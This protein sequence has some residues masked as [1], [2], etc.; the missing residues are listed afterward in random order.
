MQSVN[1]EHTTGEIYYGD[2]VHVIN[3]L[4]PFIELAE[5]VSKM[6]K[7]G[8]INDIRRVIANNYVAQLRKDLKK[9]SFHFAIPVEDLENALRS[10]D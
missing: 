3:D 9:L 1:N 5:I 7:E 8:R 6:S 4:T 10:R 2:T